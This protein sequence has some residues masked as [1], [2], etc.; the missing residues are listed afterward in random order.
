MNVNYCVRKAE[1][2]ND[3]QRSMSR[4][5]LKGTFSESTYVCSREPGAYGDVELADVD[6]AIRES[7]NALEGRC[8]LTTSV[9]VQRISLMGGAIELGVGRIS[10]LSVSVGPGDVSPPFPHRFR[11]RRKYRH[12]IS[13]LIN[14]QSSRP[15]RR[16]GAPALAPD[17]VFEL[18][19]LPKTVSL[20]PNVYCIVIC[21]RRRATRRT[22]AR[23]SDI[24]LLEA[25]GV[26]RRPLALQT[27]R[28]SNPSPS[29]LLLATN[30]TFTGWRSERRVLNASGVRYTFYY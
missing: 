21:A 3:I 18:P 2:E 7:G 20:A 26:G 10:R 24:N 11:C 9:A 14:I 23:R 5:V 30:K 22:P 19:L 15:R 27:P 28:P 13:F 29:S 4:L 16:V 1:G 6:L 12:Y 8:N 25:L 17:S